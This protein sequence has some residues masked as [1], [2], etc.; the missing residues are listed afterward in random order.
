MGATSAFAK[1]PASFT[2]LLSMSDSLSPSVRFYDSKIR[3]VRVKRFETSFVGIPV[4]SK[5]VTSKQ[6][7]AEASHPR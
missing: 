5:P 4:T 7:S 6:Q 2:K 1:F 3:A